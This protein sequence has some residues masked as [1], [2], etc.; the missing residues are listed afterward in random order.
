MGKLIISTQLTV[1]G[2]ITTDKWFIPE[3]EHAQVGFDQLVA[4][5]ALLL[6]RK[7]FVGLAEY[8]APISGDKWADEVNAKPK[9]VGSRTLTEPL[10]WNAELISGAVADGVGK[11]KAQLDGD[12]LMY[13]CGALARHLVGH[14]LVDELRFW[15]HPTVWGPGE[16]PFLDGD[17]VPLRLLAATPYDSGVTLL[18]YRPAA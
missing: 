7:T 2:V 5:E 16:R 11:L 1:D 18:R 13:G 14:G 17:P 6:G 10:S 15:V 3:G 8:W 4:A 12:L 9:F